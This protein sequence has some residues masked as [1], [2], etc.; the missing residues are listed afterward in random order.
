MGE[1]GT[2]IGVVLISAN[3]FCSQRFVSELCCIEIGLRLLLR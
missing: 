2:L 3:Q 1:V